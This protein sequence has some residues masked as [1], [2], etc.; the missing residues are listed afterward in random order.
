[1]KPLEGSI[2]NKTQIKV[3]GVLID[4]VNYEVKDDVSAKMCGIIWGRT[5]SIIWQIIDGVAIDEIS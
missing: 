4:H 1:M 5:S 2:F 3:D